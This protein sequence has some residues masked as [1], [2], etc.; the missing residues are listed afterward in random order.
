MVEMYNPYLALS[1]ETGGLLQAGEV[2]WTTAF[3]IYQPKSGKRREG[4]GRLPGSCGWGGA[5]GT[6]YWIDREAGIAVSAESNQFLPLSDTEEKQSAGHF[7]HADVAWQRA[8]GQDSEK[9]DREGC[10]RG[11]RNIDMWSFD[12]VFTMPSINTSRA[13]PSC[14]PKQIQARSCVR[15]L[16]AVLEAAVATLSINESPLSLSISEEPLLRSVLLAATS[17]AR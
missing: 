14:H 12:S 3:A 4:F 5:A 15:L 13:D 2:D 6:E 11:S 9:E 1:E 8:C 7:H 10:L 17:E 16:G